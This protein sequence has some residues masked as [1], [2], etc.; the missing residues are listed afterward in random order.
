[1]LSF[2]Q[3]FASLILLLLSEF[4]CIYICIL[5]YAF[6]CTGLCR[7][8]SPF[9]W[10]SVHVCACVCVLL[11]PLLSPQGWMHKTRPTEWEDKQGRLQHWNIDRYAHIQGDAQL[12]ALSVSVYSQLSIFQRQIVRSA[13]AQIESERDGYQNSLVGESHWG[14]WE[15][16]RGHV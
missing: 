10:A 15:R 6:F 7:I 9:L 16:V 3:Q 13:C 2:S 12:S 8:F 5:V 1:M 14:D 11:L 4:V